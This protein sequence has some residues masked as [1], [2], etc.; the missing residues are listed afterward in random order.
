VN[1]KHLTFKHIEGTGLRNDETAGWR[2]RWD[3][4]TLTSTAVALRALI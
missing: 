3:P 2:V 1:L 4:L